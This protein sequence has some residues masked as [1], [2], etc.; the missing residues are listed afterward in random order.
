M[1]QELAQDYKALV[2]DLPLDQWRRVRGKQEIIVRYEPER[3][4]ATLPEL[5]ADRDDRERLLTLME[6]MVGDARVQRSEPTAAQQAMYER[7]RRTL[8]QPAAPRPRL[9]P[10]RR[11]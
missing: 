4:I 10:V 5:L 3:A 9:S 11:A 2:P 7:I 8:L 1:R 6:K